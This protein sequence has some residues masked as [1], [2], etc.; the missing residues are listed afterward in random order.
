MTIEELGY[1]DFFAIEDGEDIPE[2]LTVARV[3]SETKG[4][5]TI[6]GE[7]GEREGECSGRLEFSAMERAELPAVG[8][9]VLADI[10]GAGPAVIHRV[11]KRRTALVRRAAG[12]KLSEQVIAANV[13]IVFIIQ[14]LDG[15]YNLRRLE[16]QLVA[17]YDSGARPVVL[18]SKGDLL[19]E[20]TR[21]ERIGATRASAP[22]LPVLCYSAVNGAGLEEVAEYFQSGVTMC[23][24]GSSGAGKSTLINR[25]AGYDLRATAAV[26]EADSRGRHTTSRR[27]LVILPGGAL[28]IDTPGMR[29]LGLWET[30]DGVDETFP[31]IAELMGRCHFADCTHTN[32]PGCA[33]IEALENGAVDVKRYESYQKLLREAAR[34][35]MSIAERHRKDRGFGKMVKEFKRFKNNKFRR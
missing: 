24:I 29:E 33:V 26:R 23:F 21:E 34:T 19:D 11:L 10:D 14:G 3:I 27:D 35:S 31:E 9:W 13:D 8:D 30:G 6:L 17:V 2:R 5:M 7:F 4:R 16:R 15:D 28:V 22:G 32:E 12:H 20:D 25:L 18:L 1:S